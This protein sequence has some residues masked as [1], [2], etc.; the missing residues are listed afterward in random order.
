MEIDRPV[1]WMKKHGIPLPTV[2]LNDRLI[3]QRRKRLLKT[4]QIC[5]MNGEVQIGMRTRLSTE[6]R[7]HAPA[8]V[9]PVIEAGRFKSAT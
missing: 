4:L 6:Q 9:D 1:D 8:A 5:E 7:I 2:L 3:P